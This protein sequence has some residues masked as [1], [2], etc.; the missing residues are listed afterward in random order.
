MSGKI[1]PIGLTPNEVTLL[2]SIVS[3]VSIRTDMRW[4]VGVIND[5]NAYFVNSDTAIGQS[6]INQ[7]GDN[8]AIL[9]YSSNS[10][11]DDVFSLQRPLRARDLYQSLE[12]IGVQ[13]LHAYRSA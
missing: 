3:I 1:A 4:E 11:P 6:F 9:K 2:R 5:S 13:D 12:F 7:Y 8:V 10:D